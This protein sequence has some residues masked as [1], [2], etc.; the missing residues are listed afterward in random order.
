MFRALGKNVD[1]RER[2]DEGL[3]DDTRGLAVARERR[4]SLQHEYLVV[5]DFDRVVEFIDN[6]QPVNGQP[7]SRRA[8]RFELDS[9]HPVGC[10]E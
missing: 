6:V 8:R 1:M 9:A 10:A 2:G 5:A 3:H 7:C 4:K